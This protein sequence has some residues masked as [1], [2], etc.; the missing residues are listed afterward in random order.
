MKNHFLN[1][2]KRMFRLGWDNFYR[3]KGI[4][5][6]AVFVLTVVIVMAT[7]IFIVGA[8]TEDIINSVKEKADI[9]IDFQ[10]SVSEDEILEVQKE[11]E[12]NFEVTS[13]KYTSKEEAKTAFMRR[14]SDRASVMESLE[15]V[16]NPFPSS[17]SIKADDPYIYQ[18]V[19]DLL[20]NKY[21]AI[22]DSVDFYH[23]QEVIEGIFSLTD[24]ARKVGVVL[25]TIMGV[26]SVLL[27]YNTVKL[28]IYEMREE[29][30]VMRLVGASNAFIQGSFIIQ[31]V[32]MGLV[33]A[34][35]SFFLLFPGGYMIVS[36]YDIAVDVDINRYVFEM[37]PLIII[38]HLGTGIILGVLSSLI[39]S[40]KHLK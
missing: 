38:I 27:V 14:F 34:V 21:S 11:I 9:T 25:V 29:I 6:V 13:I 20:E 40:N 32:L 39:A 4:S 31:G 1:S 7:S 17:L 36:P 8:I 12:D 30:R 22:V 28:A 35:L 5:F 23:R 18:Q 33:A 37:M 24:N 15:E 3:E 2:F 16:G 10:L 26:I 19:S